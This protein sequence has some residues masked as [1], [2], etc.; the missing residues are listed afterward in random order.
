MKRGILI[1]GLGVVV[2]AII[3]MFLLVVTDLIPINADTKPCQLETWIAKKAL[4]ASLRRQVDRQSNP[5]P[6]NESNAI[7]G[8]KLYADNCLVRHG[9]SDG[10]ASN[11]AQG[12]YQK[13]PQL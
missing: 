12:L 1:G 13:A 10:E 11:T 7:A 4:R 8:I 2:A 6:L 5:L 3:T 9:A